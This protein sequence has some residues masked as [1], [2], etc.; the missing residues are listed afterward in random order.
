MGPPRPDYLSQDYSN[1]GK[2]QLG[3]WFIIVNL[4]QNYCKTCAPRR[5]NL[6]SDGTRGLVAGLQGAVTALWGAVAALWG[7]VT[8][9]WGAASHCGLD[10]SV[11]W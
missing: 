9:S 2:V 5:I 11:L 8:A 3:L 7:V 6:F 4:K 10:A 1:A